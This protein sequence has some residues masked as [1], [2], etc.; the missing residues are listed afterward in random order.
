MDNP[1]AYIAMMESWRSLAS[2]FAQL[3]VA[4]L[5]LPILFL[6]KIMG[7]PDGEGLSSKINKW[8]YISWAFLFMSIGLSMAYQSTAICK[9]G[10]VSGLGTGFACKL[11][12]NIVFTSFFVSF[13]LGIFAFII[14]ALQ[15]LKE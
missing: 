3:A 7:I 13:A 6:R 1:E 4:A 8:L 15:S 11:N 10:F 5:I 2:E 9:I 14:G 12:P